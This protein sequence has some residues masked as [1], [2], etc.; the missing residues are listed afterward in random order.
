MTFQI[1]SP[2]DGSVYA[3]REPMP[4]GEARA[5]ASRAR[6]AQPTWAARPVEDRIALISGAVEKLRVM[7]DTLVTEL[8]WQMG[9]PT[10]YGGEITGIAERA[11]W[12]AGAAM[13][14]L[15]PLDIEDS[16]AFVRRIE[17]DPLGVI[18]VI[19]PWNYPYLV[20]I[21]GV[22]PALIAGNTVILKHSEQTML[23]GERL[24]EALHAAGVPED[25][26]QNIMVEHPVAETLMAE[27]AFDAIG[28]TGSVGAGRAVEKAAAGSFAAMS[29]ELGGKDPAYVMEDADLDAA[30]EGVMDAVTFNA[31]Q[32]C[33]GIERIYVHRSKYDAFVEGAVAWTKALQLGNPFDADTTLGPMAAQRFADTVRRHVADAKAAGAQALIDP[34]LFPAD[35]GGAYVAPQILVDVTHDMDAMREETFGPIVGVMPVDSDDEALA[36]MNDSPF[37][38]TASL[39]SSDAERGLA[40]G[41]RIDTGTVFLNRADYLDPALCWTGC[42]QSGRG[43]TLSKLGFESVTRPRSYHLRKMLS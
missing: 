1:I 37:G 14:A 19:A 28:F 29:L 27:R 26:F 21:N 9:R 12:M 4:L 41:R 24:A 5:A 38:L 22:F 40:L 42:K 13:D 2:V 30:I 7:N 3:E 11:D 34:K 43:A 6:S 32:C 20:A 15:A 33:C 17:R 31:G 25:V 16:D 18:F 39:W 23:T 35:D 10:R 36:L 8:A